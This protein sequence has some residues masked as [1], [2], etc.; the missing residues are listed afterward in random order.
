MHK[1]KVIYVEHCSDSEDEDSEDEDDEEPKAKSGSQKTLIT[2]WIK[3]DTGA[4]IPAEPSKPFKEPKKKTSPFQAS[5]FATVA[6]C[7]LS[8]VWP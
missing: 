8:F 2:R 4:V 7:F 5:S 3:S 6:K 1:E